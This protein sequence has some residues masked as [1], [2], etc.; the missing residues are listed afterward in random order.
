MHETAAELDALQA[1]LD[2]SFE[3]ASAHLKSIMTPERRLPSATLVERLPLPAVLNIATVTGRGE[4]RIS[5]VDGHFLHGHW[6]FTTAGDSP[7][8]RQLA[9]RPAIS[10]SYTPRDGFGVFAHGTA[11]RLQGNERRML[12]EHY[13]SHY[14]SDPESL[15]DEIAYYRMDADWLVA[16]AMTDAEQAAIDAKRR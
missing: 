10:A 16:F 3:R 5:A 1:L 14:G 6:Y 15:A 2:A 4:P 13:N 12:R 11:A 9:A 7:K 8:A